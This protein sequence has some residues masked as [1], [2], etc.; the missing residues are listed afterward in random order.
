MSFT[1][2][3]AWQSDSP[4]I[5]NRKFIEDALR[6]A[7]AAI[8]QERSLD[9]SPIIDFGMERTPGSPEVATIMFR[10][11]GRSAIFVGDVTLVGEIKITG[12]KTAN[13]NVLVEMGYAAAYLGWERIIC[14]LNDHE[15]F[16]KAEDQPIDV[17]NRRFPIR[18]RLDPSTMAGEAKTKKDLTK[19]LRRAI[20]TIYYYDLES[21]NDA[22]ALLDINCFNLIAKFGVSPWFSAPN[23]EKS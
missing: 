11:I 3:Y 10:K 9:Y 1:I 15:S 23:P 8:E 2:F 17:R 6:D 12:K 22:I 14:V 20:E 4:P 18:Y 19:D 16:G 13:P 21:A 5:A 7:V